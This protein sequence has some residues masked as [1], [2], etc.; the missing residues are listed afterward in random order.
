MKQIIDKFL[1]KKSIRPYKV[2]PL[3][4]GVIVEHYRN[5]KLKT[6]YYERLV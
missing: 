3:S 1:I 5:G 4:T 6:E 2:V